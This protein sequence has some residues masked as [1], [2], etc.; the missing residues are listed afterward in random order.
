MKRRLPRASG[1]TSAAATPASNKAIIV[2]NA[3]SPALNML[4][5]HAPAMSSQHNRIAPKPHPSLLHLPA[6]EMARHDDHR[7]PETAFAPMAIGENAVV[8]YL[9]KKSGTV[10]CAFSISSSS[11]VL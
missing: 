4:H 2:A 8:E 11:T 10:G 5:D 3:T 7:L 9:R 6:A 1:H